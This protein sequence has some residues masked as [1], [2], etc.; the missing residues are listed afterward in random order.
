MP[1]QQIGEL[2][3]SPQKLTRHILKVLAF[4]LALAVFAMYFLDQKLAQFFSQAEIYEIWYQPARKL[5]DL[6]LFEFYFV[7][8]LGTWL[9]TKF[10]VPTVKVDFFRRWGLNFLAALVVSGLLT[11]LIKFSVG[12]QR[13]HKSPIHDP[14]IFTP[15]T[16]H[17][18]WH[19][20]SSGHTQVMF[21]FATMLSLALPKWRWLWIS[22][23]LI[24]SFT[25]VMV[26]DHFL[27]DTIVGACIGYVGTLMAL[28][29]MKRK[30]TNGLF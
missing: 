9:I 8:A 24:I 6:G 30:T 25:R 26:I 21:T 18:H 20:F 2:L 28:Y 17:F 23:A 11:H 4:A 27:S 14:W 10:K 5:T 29:L 16:T 1:V 19:S 7:L 12:R 22:F 13:P 3:N 15:F